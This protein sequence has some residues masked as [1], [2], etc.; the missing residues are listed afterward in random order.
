ML[1]SKKNGNEDNNKCRIELRLPVLA[2][3]TTS[4]DCYFVRLHNTWN[5]GS[6]CSRVCRQKKVN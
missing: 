4:I 6:V 5:C 1:P 2:D 3:R